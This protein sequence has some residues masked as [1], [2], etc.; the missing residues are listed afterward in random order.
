L[1]DAFAIVAYCI[2]GTW[3]VAFVCATLQTVPLGM[4]HVPNEL[5][6]AD[7]V[8][9]VDVAL[10]HAQ[11]FV[12]VG[13]NCGQGRC[14]E[15]RPNINRVR[16]VDANASLIASSCGIVEGTVVV[17]DAVFGTHPVCSI[18]DYIVE[19]ST[20]ATDCVACRDARAVF[21]D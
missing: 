1:H 12:V 19:T 5:V 13:A 9:R 17:V 2:V 7:A 16:R 8:S 14:C 11:T 20:N 10:E 15:W 4:F 18:M 6:Q 21:V 3:T